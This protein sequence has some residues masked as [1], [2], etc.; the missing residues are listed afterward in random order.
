M[1]TA[2]LSASNKTPALA[3]FAQGLVELGWK[4]LGSVGTKK[5][6]DEQ[7]VPCTDIGDIV[8]PA[9]LGH[10][11]VTL[12]R[13][14]YAAIL[15]RPEKEDDMAELKRLGI[16]R[17]SLVYVDLYPLAHELRHPESTYR[18]VLEKVDIGG[19]TLLRAAA[20]G[21]CLVLCEEKQMTGVLEFLRLQLEN[22][23]RTIVATNRFQ[24]GLAAQAELK[25][26]EYAALSAGFYESVESGAFPHKW[27]QKVA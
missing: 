10:R 3:R 9:I 17:I 16:E 5:F 4:I 26:S 1:Q 20:K 18:S 24:A 19:P 23:P 11:V 14:I 7:G 8:G 27:R 6:L 15:A 12:D 22:K 25:V 21:G 13:K 2:L